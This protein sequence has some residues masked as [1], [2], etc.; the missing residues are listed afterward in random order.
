MSIGNGGTPSSLLKRF[1]FLDHYGK[2]SI[3]KLVA[4]VLKRNKRGNP[5]IFQLHKTENGIEIYL[6]DLL[7]LLPPRN[8]IE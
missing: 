5:K 2:G 6:C 8:G 4:F 7:T 1:Y 3:K